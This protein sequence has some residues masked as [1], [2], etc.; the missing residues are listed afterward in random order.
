MDEESPYIDAHHTQFVTFRRWIL[1]CKRKGTHS[2]PVKTPTT[3][4]H[5]TTADLSTTKSAI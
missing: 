2:F 3:K 5:K 1:E 4:Q